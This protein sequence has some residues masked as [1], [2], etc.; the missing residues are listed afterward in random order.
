MMLSLE[1]KICLLKQ[2]GKQKKK[3]LK[4][5]VDLHLALIQENQPGTDLPGNIFS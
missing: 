2:R 4:Q 3:K 1:V 5:K